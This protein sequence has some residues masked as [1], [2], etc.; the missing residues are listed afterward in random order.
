M[1]LAITMTQG[2]MIGIIALM[3]V[4]GIC[5]LIFTQMGKKN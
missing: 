2:W 1:L 5:A 3:I 4:F